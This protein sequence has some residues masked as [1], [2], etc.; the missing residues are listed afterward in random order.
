[1]NY[2]HLNPVGF[3]NVRIS[4]EFWSRR[5]QTIREVTAWACIDECEK[6]HR[7]DNFRRAAGLQ[8]GGHEGI[9]FND[10]DVYK[11][12]EGAAYVLMGGADPKLEAKV[13]EIIDAIC[14]AQQED[15][16]LY[17]YYTLNTPEKRWT[18]MN[19]HEAY[20]LGHMIEGALAY[21]QATGKDKWLKAACRAVD[22]MMRVNGPEGQHWVTGHQEIELAL[23]KLYRH[24]GEQKYLDY[25]KW[26]VEERGHGH[27]RS[28]SL[29]H[30]MYRNTDYCQDDRPVRELERVTGHAVR[31]MYY[32]SAVTDLAA[33]LGDE[34]L[35]EAMCRVWGNVVPA[36]LYL[37]GG[38]GQSAHNEGFTRDWS[39]PNL[40]AYC[41]T[42]A[43]IGMAMWN[44]RM[45]F[46]H[47]ES[48]YAD[49][50]ERELYNGVLSGISL[51][52]DKFFYDNPLAS[53]GNYHRSTWFGC[54]CCPTN[55][56]RFIPS[57]GGYVYAVSGDEIYLN[58]F[59]QSETKVAT[60]SGEVEI[61]VETRYPWEG[62]VAV[63]IVRCEGERVL[64]VRKPEWCE[65][66][67]LRLNGTLVEK[68]ENGYYVVAV[69][70][71]DCIEYDMDMS[72]KRVYADDRVAEDRGRVAVMRGPVVYC[73]E[74]TDNPGIV[75]EYFHAEKA[76][77]KETVLTAQFEP[78]L[79]GGVVTIVGDGVRLVPYYAWDNREPGA[80]V[81]WMKEI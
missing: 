22:Q 56:I 45:N 53:V 81:V 51:S 24:T 27:L 76:L 30:L 10:S 63:R 5:I 16:Y 55:L 61:A 80:M 9:F 66:A 71:N 65:R 17:T 29:K 72:I 57:V 52:G 31:A 37:T 75:S 47:G 39:L 7:V 20:C 6:T 69:H 26:L 21:V 15:G 23:V 12:L 13:D 58:Q 44:Q 49:L 25:A 4:D 78:E 2:V 79:L 28:E 43:A 64:R 50:V 1:M 77:P 68:C 62:S 60:A 59:I 48:K 8:E 14:A 36:N 32:Y 74:E 41:E 40:T 73:A 70:E 35:D 54:S 38:I 42:C 67:E 46:T 18:D 33:I 11:V 34:S 3:Q 19:H